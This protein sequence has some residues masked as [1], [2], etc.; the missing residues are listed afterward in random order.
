MVTACLATVTVPT[1]VPLA[2]WVSVSVCPAWSWSGPAC[3]GGV[4]GGV[5]GAGGGVAGLAGA[6]AAGDD[7][8]ATGVDMA[9][10]PPSR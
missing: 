6:L 7:G 9:A 5:A 3:A 4:V 2:V 10:V 1:G 8:W